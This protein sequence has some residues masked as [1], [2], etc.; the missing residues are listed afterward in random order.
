MSQLEEIGNEMENR[1]LNLI[2]ILKEVNVSGF[3]DNW[4]PMRILQVYDPEVNMQGILVIDNTVLG[5]GCGFIK[6]SPVITCREVFHNARVM[7]WACALANVNFGGASAG[8]KANPSEINKNLFIRAFA[9]GISAYVPDQFIAV[10]GYDVG[11]A[12][13][14][15]FT[16]EVGDSRG[17]IN[18]DLSS[19]GLGIG[20]TIGAAIDSGLSSFSL[21]EKLSDV[22]I[23]I[24][25]FNQTGCAAAK[26]LANK[27]AKIIAISDDWCTISDPKGIELEVVYKHCCAETERKSL[28]QCKGFKKHS[29][30]EIVKFDCDVFIA[31]SGNGVFNEEIA[32]S[33]KAKCIVE[34]AYRPMP[35][36]V[37][38]TLHNRGVLV[39]P[40]ILTAACEA[41][42]A[43][44]NQNG[45]RPERALSLMETR[46]NEITKQTVTQAIEQDIPLRR[47]CRDVAQE[48]ILKAMEVKNGHSL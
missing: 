24:Q 43:Y 38:Q 5:A 41:I 1:K 29:K 17:A 37:D 42:I 19:L 10:P 26:Y 40:D 36:V 31:G 44:G 39:I 34:S 18:I 22:K 30:E 15:A 33:L 6:I 46:M 3:L 47:I 20:I 23:V 25:G 12:E 11:R 45:N 27:G 2:E 21:P 48:R 9:K 28:K 14:A 32:N 16:D 4:G 35:G 13:M 7:T 8:I